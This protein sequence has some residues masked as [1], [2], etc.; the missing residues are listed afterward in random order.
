MSKGLYPI[1]T[2]SA[3]TG[4][5]PVTLRA[6][7]R[8]YG[9]I[10]PQRTPKGHR[11]YTERDIDRIQQVLALLDRGIPISQAQQVLDD[12]EPAAAP[13]D[14]TATPADAASAWEDQQQQWRAA[15]AD[16]DEHALDSAYCGTLTLFPVDHTHERLVR[17]LLAE[18]AAVAGESHKEAARYR[19]FSAFLRNK[20]GARFHH[21]SIHASGPRLVAATPA[22]ECDDVGLLLAAVS[23]QARGYR[24]VL[25]GNSVTATTL[26]TACSLT[27]ASG[28]LISSARRRPPHDLVAALDHGRMPVFCLDAAAHWANGPANGT[29][30]PVRDP[31]RLL[32]ILAHHLPA[33]GD[34]GPRV[35]D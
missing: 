26:I 1:R 23:A 20:L 27:S 24:V 11:L 22:G 7:E 28:V 34:P 29:L 30:I 6:W 32:R 21:Q 19:F 25:L 35:C 16:L 17:P 3:M 9:L 10:R 4:V 8:R 31:T 18:L 2:I 33:A 13:V 15:V 12:P 5:N 14:T